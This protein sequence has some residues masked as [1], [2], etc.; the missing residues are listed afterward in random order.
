[1]PV[2]GEQFGLSGTTRETI[3]T[4]IGVVEAKTR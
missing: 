2:V 3:L 4:A 1:L